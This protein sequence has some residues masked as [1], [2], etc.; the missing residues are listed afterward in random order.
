MGRS[1]LVVEDEYVDLEENTSEDDITHQTD[2]LQNALIVQP[3]VNRVSIIQSP[4]LS[5]FYYTHP[6]H[7]TLD[8]RA[9]TNMIKASNAIQGQGYQSTYLTC[10]PDGSSSQRINPFGG[11]E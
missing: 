8:T 5:V 4:N 6:T 11:S 7:L 2:E 9:T 10:L 1:R 3:S